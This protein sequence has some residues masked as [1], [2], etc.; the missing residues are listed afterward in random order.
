MC[1]CF[2]FVI[3]DET[4]RVIST[5]VMTMDPSY[6]PVTF[7]A[8]DKK[9]LPHVSLVFFLYTENV[10]IYPRKV[11]RQRERKKHFFWQFISNLFVTCRHLSPWRK[12]SFD[13]E[14]SRFKRRSPSDG[15]SIASRSF[16]CVVTVR[17]R[18]NL[19]HDNDCKHYVCVCV[20]EREI[21]E[22]RCNIFCVTKHSKF[23]IQI[24]VW[25]RKSVV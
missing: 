25:D 24:K 10:N 23:L 3:D 20:W 22:R 9:N 2:S 1:F 19:V 18:E 4:W 7:R 6:E 8:S 15:V 12:L 14:A 11:S 16:A 21:Y 5:N 17:P 13:F